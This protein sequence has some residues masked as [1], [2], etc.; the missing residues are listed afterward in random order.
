MMHIINLIFQQSATGRKRNIYMGNDHQLLDDD[1]DESN[2][3]DRGSEKNS[4]KS[5]W[6]HVANAIDVVAF[7][8]TSLYVIFNI[9]VQ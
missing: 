5:Q 6:I 2:T 3:E 1:F 8:A 9:F 7:F 4:I